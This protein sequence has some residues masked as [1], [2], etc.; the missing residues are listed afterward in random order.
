MFNIINVLFSEQI[1]HENYDVDGIDFE[2]LLRAAP[3]YPVTVHIMP[4]GNYS[5]HSCR[6]VQASI[7][8]LP[9]LP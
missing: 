8:L 1:Y 6:A 4:L 9:P 2:A 3:M 5:K 7:R